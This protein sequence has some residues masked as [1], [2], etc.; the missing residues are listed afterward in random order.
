MCSVADTTWVFPGFDNNKDH[1]SWIPLPHLLALSLANPALG[2][3]THFHYTNAPS[4]S[5]LKP[6]QPTTTPSTHGRPGLSAIIQSASDDAE[7]RV[8]VLVCG[9]ASLSD[10]VV[11]VCAGVCDWRRVAR[12]DEGGDVRVEVELFD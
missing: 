10:A 1:L 11:D 5:S 9:P 2:I 6:P 7:G 12:G 4:P 8:Q 3:T